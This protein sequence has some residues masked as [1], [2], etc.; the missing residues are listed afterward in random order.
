M[1]ATNDCNART[2]SSYPRHNDILIFE[3]VYVENVN[4]EYKTSSVLTKSTLC[5]V[6]FNIS[7]LLD[8]IIREIS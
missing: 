5:W 2:W 8:K 6:D 1:S 7:L 4:D 3:F